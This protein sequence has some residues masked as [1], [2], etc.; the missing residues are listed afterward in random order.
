MRQRAVA[1]GG[2]IGIAILP[3]AT[4]PLGFVDESKS[5]ATVAG[6]VPANFVVAVS[7]DGSVAR[8]VARH[9]NVSTRP[10]EAT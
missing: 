6:G 2:V 7:G 10:W 1:E 8:L 3:G 5:A 4:M 9:Y